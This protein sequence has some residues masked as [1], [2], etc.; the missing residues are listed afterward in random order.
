MFCAYP[1]NEHQHQAGTKDQ[2][3]CR[4][5]CRCYQDTNDG[6]RH[7]NRQKAFF[8]IFDNILFTAKLPAHVHKKGQL[9]KVRRLECHVDHR[10]FDPPAAGIQLHTKQ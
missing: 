1:A 3:R 9:G 8:E 2:N 6:N 5:V 10:Q 4:Q 7:N